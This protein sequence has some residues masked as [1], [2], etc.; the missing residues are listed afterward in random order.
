MLQKPSVKT[1][2]RLAILT[3]TALTQAEQ[4]L[5]SSVAST[6]NII[7]DAC[8]LT[9]LDEP[10][11]IDALR[12]FQPNLVLLLGNEP[13]RKAKTYVNF[14]RE[15]DDTDEDED[16]FFE[17]KTLKSKSPIDSY[18]GSLFIGFENQYKCL[19]TY[20]PK[21]I[22]A[23]YGDEI[24]PFQLDLRRARQEAISPVLTLPKRNLEVELS[25]CEILDRLN[26]LKG[27][28]A[29]DI[30]GYVHDMTCIAFATSA[31]HAFIVPTIVS[32]WGELWPEM[33]RTLARVLEDPNIPKVFQNGLYDMFVLQYSYSIAV[34]G[35]VGDTMLKHWELFCELPKSLGFQASIYTREPY[36]K[37][38]RHASD[39]LTHWRYCCKDAAIT[40]EINELLDAKLSPAQRR[41]YDFNVSL[42]DPLLYM[43]L[44]GLPFDTALRD[45][46]LAEIEP[47]LGKLV[48]IVNTLAGY[49]LDSVDWFSV[50]TDYACYK[51]SIV[52]DLASFKTNQKASVKFRS[53]E[54]LFEPRTISN[55]GLLCH[56]T[57]QGLNIASPQAMCEFLYDILQLPEQRKR[58][59]RERTADVLALL[60]L[61]AKTNH[62]ILYYILLL[63]SINTR[64]KNL[65]FAIDADNRVRSAYNLVG[66]D[67]GRLTCYKSPTGTGFNLQ[68]QTKFDR[69]LFIAD[70]G[71]FLWQCDLTGADGW[72]VAAKCAALGDPTMIED[73]RFG[74]KPA[75]LI[76]LIYTKGK[77]VISWSREDIKRACAEIDSD[78]WLYFTC[79]CVQHGSNYLMGPPTVV[80]TVVRL[81]YKLYGEP[82]HVPVNTC[83]D[84]QQCYFIRYPGIKADQQHV[85]SILQKTGQL[86]SAS[87]HVRT[88]FGRR[89]DKNTVKQAL[90]DEAQNNTTYAINMAL[91]NLWY[92]RENRDSNG[93]LIIRCLHQMHDA[94]IG[95]L[96]RD[97]VD[98]SL[99]KIRSYL[100]NT[101]R[102]AGMDITIPFEGAYGPTWKHL[103]S[104]YGGGEI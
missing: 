75:K 97:R 78:G 26:N 103:G 5:L 62:P 73:Y 57:K 7:L 42:L 15:T 1:Q 28:V 61:Y 11:Y 59:T 99:H 67:T 83:E 104:K 96:P 49:D 74:I 55:I 47:L 70:P 81:S 25:P 44:V 12:D 18:R 63:R 34:R 64:A 32:F 43:E 45:K 89:Y 77:N 17:L 72:T 51:N 91:R 56:Q 86:T 93:N 101:I 80:D 39:D 98:F 88:F 13:L 30:E 35:V 68:T 27:L 33:W 95:T 31:S 66:T 52:I 24:F 38:E 4:N 40:Y 76:A 102:I 60:K 10:G 21:T 87:G 85:A 36:Y 48:Y 3:T 37:V 46:K 84:L 8:L 16:D 65:H 79:K 90:A 50:A 9:T 2:Y 69:D 92:D 54:L 29:C 20:E 58:K 82:I 100:N 23:Y 41:H 14:D 6:A 19:A 71:T 94:L 53:P 22:F